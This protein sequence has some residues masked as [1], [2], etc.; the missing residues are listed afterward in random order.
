MKDLLKIIAYIKVY[1]LDLYGVKHTN[2][3][4]GKN[5]LESYF[6]TKLKWSE[7]KLKRLT[8]VLIQAGILRK[9]KAEPGFKFYSLSILHKLGLKLIESN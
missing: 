3:N 9:E 1:G 8:A 5:N 7:A 4:C 2:I 6:C